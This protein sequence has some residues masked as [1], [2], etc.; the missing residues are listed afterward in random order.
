MR[1]NALLQRAH[2]FCDSMETSEAQA[3]CDKAIK[4]NSSYGDIYVQMA[5]VF[6]LLW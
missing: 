3:E 2:I 5:K 4:L 6:W 1:I